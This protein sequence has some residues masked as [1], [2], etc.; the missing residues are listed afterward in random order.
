MKR[1]IAPKSPALPNTMV[2][3]I[4]MGMGSRITKI[5]ALI[6]QDPHLVRDVRTAM[7]VFLSRA[8]T[9]LEA[10]DALTQPD[11]E[12]RIPRAIVVTEHGKQDQR[13]FRVIGGSDILALLAAVG[14]H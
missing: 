10:I 2:A 11:R 4:L 5:C 7:A 6:S 14:K 9:A 8:A 12:G 3:Q 1:M 13:P